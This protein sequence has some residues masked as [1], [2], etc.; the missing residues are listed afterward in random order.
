[1]YF[2]LPNGKVIILSIEEYL[3]LTDEDIQTLIA[4]NYGDYPTSHWYGSCIYYQE[5]VEIREENILMSL[6][7]Q[8]EY[9]QQYPNFD[10]NNIPDEEIDNLELD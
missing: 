10:I 2:Q 4:L 6:E 3:C 9:L 5:S 8:D 7:E 1:M